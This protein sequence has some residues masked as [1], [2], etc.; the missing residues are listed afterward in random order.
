MNIS[1]ELPVFDFPKQGVGSIIEQSLEGAIKWTGTPPP[2][3]VVTI[4]QIDITGT[5]HP[6]LLRKVADGQISF[7]KRESSTHA[8]VV[9]LRNPSKTIICAYSFQPRLFVCLKTPDNCYIRCLTKKELAQIQGFPADHQF[10][11]NDMSVVK[12]IG[13]AVPAKLIEMISR[14]ILGASQPK[15]IVLRKMR[16]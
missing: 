14:S 11:G 2:E 9:D 12:Q 16:Q 7:G 5:P 3:C 15:P 10:Y 1:Y 8:E 4:P 13:N 6:Y